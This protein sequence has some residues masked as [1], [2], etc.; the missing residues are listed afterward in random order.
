MQIQAQIP[1]N[2]IIPYIH[3]SQKLQ[4]NPIKTA[5][6]SGAK[7]VEQRTVVVIDERVASSNFFINTDP[8]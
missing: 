2:S 8:S 3:V 4:S 7:P 5:V 6:R 1:F